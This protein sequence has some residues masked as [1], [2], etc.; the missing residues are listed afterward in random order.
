MSVLNDI[1]GI[2]LL[3]LM[4]AGAVWCWTQPEPIHPHAA[5]LAR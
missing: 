1:A 5:A 4:L 2:A 3:S